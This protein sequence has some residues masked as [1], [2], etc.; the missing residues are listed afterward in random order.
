MNIMYIKKTLSVLL[1]LLLC[2]LCCATGY[3]ENSVLIEFDASYIDGLC[4]AVGAECSVEEWFELS[5]ARAAI[6]VSLCS[7]L[8]NCSD[9]MSEI[10]LKNSYVAR[11]GDQLIVYVHGENED[12]DAMI[13]YLIDSGTAFCSFMPYA[14]DRI[15]TKAIQKIVQD[16]CYRNSRKDIKKVIDMQL[17]A[18]EEQR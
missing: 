14:E 5:L 2:V 16:G 11:D 15:V 3:C 8:Y 10:Y 4:K 7:E 6:T 13:L 18:R 9:W 12:E 1:V 17:K